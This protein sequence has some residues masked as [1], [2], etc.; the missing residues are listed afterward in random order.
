M[1]LLG[2]NRWAN[3]AVAI[4]LIAGMASRATAQQ[5]AAIAPERAATFSAF[6]QSYGPVSPPNAFLQFC[7]ERPQEC[8]A[9]PIAKAR[10]SANPPRLSQ[11]DQINRE[12]NHAIAPVTD[13][14]HYGVADYWTLPVDGKGDCEDYA[15]LKRHLLIRLGWPASALLMTVVLDEN[16]EGHAILTART[17]EGD[18]ILDNKSDRIVRW[19]ETKYQYVMRQSFIDPRAWVDLNPADDRAAAS[20]AGIHKRP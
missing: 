10:F 9:T 3:A 1:S 17:A 8:V 2:L 12:V 4:L 14:E 20:V 6:M 11:L 15:L 18:Y 5:V 7:E 19:N 13:M 16:S